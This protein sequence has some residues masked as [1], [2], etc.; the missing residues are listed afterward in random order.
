MPMINASR[1]ACFT[2]IMRLAIAVYLV[3]GFAFS[4]T[5]D[6]QTGG[7]N[8]SWTSTTDLQ[9]DGANPTRTTESHTQS[10]NR[11]LDNQS[12]QRRGSNGQFEPYQDIERETVKVNATT[13]RTTTR[14]F[15]RDSDGAKTLVQVT[16]EERRSLPGGDSNVIRIT[17]NPDAN[18]N[19]Q[20]VQREV[21][22]T[23]RIS[24]NIEETKTTVMLLGINGGVSPVMQVQ[25]RRERGANTVESQKTT[26]LPDGVGNWQV[27]ETRHDITRQDGKNRNTEE[28]VSRPDPEGK[29]AE[30]SRTVSKESETAPGEKHNTSETYSVDV[31][32]SSRDGSLHLVE[33]STVAQS[34]SS[35]GQQT[36]Q[37]Q[38]EQ[39]DPGNPDSGL[40]VTILTTDSVSP[41]ASGAQATRTIQMRDPNGSLEVVS[42]DTTKSDKVNTVQVQIAPPENPK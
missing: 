12:V 21:E 42:V 6:S 15:G 31:P 37:R 28:R 29:L 22:A 18:G 23:K 38:V 32:G 5:S 14:T 16:E 13:V 1:A 41:G 35:T 7:A 36:T 9:S 8:K 33:R 4:Q 26:L 19:L 11:T 25:E 24:K 34:T 3:S 2:V 27:S 40:Q 17:S 39:P 10:G 30:I 20:L